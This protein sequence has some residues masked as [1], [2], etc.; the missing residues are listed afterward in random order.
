MAVW[1]DSTGKDH[2][3]RIHGQKASELK[4]ALGLDL[5]ACLKNPQ[6]VEAV[7]RQLQEPAMVMACCAKV[8]GIPDQQVAAFYE[9]W[10]GDAFESAG[11]ALMEAIADFFPK[12]PRQVFR[13]I[14][15]KAM[16]AV[17]KTQASSL[18]AAMVAVEKMDFHSVL[19][20]SETLGNGGT[21]SVP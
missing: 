6:A 9:L 13:R 7:L 19:N 10:D 8:E 17:Q 18:E 15:E 5:M 20:A 14:L 11:A 12:A 3:L 2:V 21:A 1:R 16:T 4:T